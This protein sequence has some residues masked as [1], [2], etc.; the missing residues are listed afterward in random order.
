[1]RRVRILPAARGDI[2]RLVAFLK[3]KSPAAADA[4]AARISKAILSL[5]QTPERGRKGS[6][7]D[8]RE[9]VVRFGRDAY[10]I[11]YRVEPSDVVVARIFHSREDRS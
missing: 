9:L 11:Q 2:A 7:E 3:H 1:L 5:D 8:L 6:R 4:A 10:I